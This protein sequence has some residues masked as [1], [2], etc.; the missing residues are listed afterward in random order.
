M[1][2]RV[3]RWESTVNIFKSASVSHG[4]SSISQ[5]LSRGE[6]GARGELCQEGAETAEEGQAEQGEKTPKGPGE[7][8]ATGQNLK[9]TGV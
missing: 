2:A 3:T 5:P 7:E 4:S 6:K 1:R 9:F 8:N